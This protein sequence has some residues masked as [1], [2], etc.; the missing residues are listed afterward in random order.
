MKN[1]CKRKQNNV[2]IISSILHI[3]IVFVIFVFDF[4]LQVIYSLYVMNAIILLVSI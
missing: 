2:V 4:L 3:F 1:N